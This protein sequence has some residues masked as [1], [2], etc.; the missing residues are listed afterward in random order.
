MLSREDISNLQSGEKNHG[1][2]NPAWKGN[3]QINANQLVREVI[4]NEL[5]GQIDDQT[6]WRYRDL[7]EKDG[8][9]ELREVIETKD[10]EIDRLLAVNREP[11]KPE[12]NQPNF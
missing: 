3:P 1:A 8:R 9:S 4:H 5:Q 10:G 7:K 12:Q 11:L 6:L 2:Q